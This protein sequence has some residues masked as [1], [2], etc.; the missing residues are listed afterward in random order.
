[1]MQ[2]RLAQAA[3]LWKFYL[4]TSGITMRIKSPSYIGARMGRPE[5][6]KERK[7]GWLTKRSIPDRSQ[8]Q[9]HNKIYKTLRGRDERTVNLELV[10]R[11][12]T[13]CKNLHFYLHAKFVRAKQLLKKNALYAATQLT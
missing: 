3:S 1:M 5:K 2:L 9:K 4:K 10:N 12:C 7:M 13:S 8:K 6:G 11:R